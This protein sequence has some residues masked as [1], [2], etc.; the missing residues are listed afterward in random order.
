[1]ARP[2]KYKEEFCDMV[3]DFL[4]EN[5]DEQYQLTK[6]SSSKGESW[7]NKI[8]VKLPTQYAFA[9]Y[10]GVAEDTVIEWS[11]KYPRFSESLGK[12]LA[13]QKQRL[14]DMGLSGDYNS[15]IAKLI[16]SA[17]HGLA[18]RK[19]ITSGDKPIPILGALLDDN[20]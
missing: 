13:E 6:S 16:L 15:T 1:M 9:K 14:L 10:I 18:E 7:D 5:R 11:K 20:K 4:K 8:K 17:N 2:T 19:D 3:D 12:I